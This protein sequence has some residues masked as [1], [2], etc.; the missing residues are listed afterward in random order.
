[1]GSSAHYLATTGTATATPRLVATWRAVAAVLLMGWRRWPR[2]DG[3]APYAP[4]WVAGGPPRSLAVF[5]F[6]ITTNVWSPAVL[7]CC[8]SRAS[9]WPRPAVDSRAVAC[10]EIVVWGSRGLLLVSTTARTPPTTPG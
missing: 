8:W 10:S 9:A 6:L 1:M 4:V 7:L 3:L 2:S 5:A